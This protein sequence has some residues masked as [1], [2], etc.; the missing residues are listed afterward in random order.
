M[1][2]LY[3]RSERWKLRG[4]YALIAMA[5]FLLGFNSGRVMEKYRRG[6]TATSNKR[7]PPKTTTQPSDNVVQEEPTKPASS[8]NMALWMPAILALFGSLIVVTFTAS[9]N[10]KSVTSQ[11]DA[12]TSKIDALR[13]EMKQYFAEFRLETRSDALEVR[14]RVERLEAQRRR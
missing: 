4:L 9:L 13:A 7:E 2:S 5:V 6:P 3:T 14:H 1:A 8:N 11:I 12:V 10:T